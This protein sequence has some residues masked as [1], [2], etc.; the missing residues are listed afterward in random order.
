MPGCDR[1]TRDDAHICDDSLDD[2]AKLLGDVT[3][4]DDEL[5]TTIAKQK[6]AGDIGSPSAEIALP[7]H[8]AASERAETLRHEL[9]MLV[10]FCTE[11]GIRSSD[12]SRAMPANTII[13]MSRWLLWR[14][15]GLAFNDM[16]AEII[17]SV[18]KAIRDCRKI[19]DLPPERSYAGPCPECKR[20]LYH[21]PDAAEAKCP[22]CGQRFDVAEVNA[23]MRDRINDHLAGRLVT[24]SEGATYLGRLGIEVA[25]RTIDKWHERKRLAGHGH[26][27]RKRRLYRWEDVL[28]LAGRE[29]RKAS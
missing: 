7:Y 27:A 20:D 13:A 5:R 1:P 6:S 2:F 19:I 26:D 22:G 11:E 10:R 12:P 28:E 8:L 16:A 21:R 23:W 17:V 3:W 4:L 14:V 18:S 9:V 25:Q 24:A 15:D 29:G